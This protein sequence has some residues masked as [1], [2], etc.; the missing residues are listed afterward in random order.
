MPSITVSNIDEDLKQRLEEQAAKHGC[1]MEEEA[2]RILAAALPQRQ[3]KEGPKEKGEMMPSKGLG[4][5]IHEHFKPVA[6]TDEEYAIF[7]SAFERSDESTCS[8]HSEE[9]SSNPC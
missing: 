5:E 1:S 3:A 9:A 4:T 7:T 2:R 6:L 8:C